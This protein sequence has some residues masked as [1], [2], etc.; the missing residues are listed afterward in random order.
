MS[1][2][3]ISKQSTQQIDV[4]AGTIIQPK[5]VPVLLTSSI[6]GIVL[7]PFETFVVKDD[8]TI[9]IS[10]MSFKTAVI[11][12]EVLANTV[13]VP[14][15]PVTAAT[16]GNK[17]TEPVIVGVT[18]DALSV[19]I[20]PT[21]ATKYTTSVSST[22]NIQL[23]AD[24]SFHA[25]NTTAG[26]ITLVV[27]NK[28]GSTVGDLYNI[29]AQNLAV[30]FPAIPNG[31]LGTTYQIAST[32]TPSGLTG[33]T[34]E[35]V[36]SDPTIASVT[37]SG[38]ITFVAVGTVTITVTVAYRG[39]QASYSAS[40][41]AIEPTE[42]IIDLSTVDLD[43]RVTI[44]ESSPTSRVYWDGVS[45]YMSVATTNEPSRQMNK[46]N[47]EYGRLGYTSIVTYHP[48]FDVINVGTD[49][50]NNLWVTNSLSD[51]TIGGSPN[52]INTNNNTITVPS[53]WT[54]IS[55]YNA[56]S[57]V[58]LRDNSKP[59]LTTNEAGTWK[60]LYQSLPTGGGGGSFYLY[61]GNADRSK[62]VYYKLT[63]L[64]SSTFMGS[65]FFRPVQGDPTKIVYSGLNIVLGTT[66]RNAATVSLGSSNQTVAVYSNTP[67]KWNRYEYTLD[68]GAV[69]NGSFNGTSR[70]LS[71]TNQNLYTKVRFY[72]L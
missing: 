24:K 20:V 29:T 34:Y 71:E 25:L 53:D 67:G 31:N 72:N 66:F 48:N 12:S 59:V 10:N 35:Y 2:I 45:E 57:G 42:E 61:I 11:A 51:I 43:P 17:P 56:T 28:D 13:V 22:A 62:Y 3:K 39:V 46:S 4:V 36:S 47:G 15:I 38:L 16:F 60:R 21:D 41:N 49:A 9:S 44:N 6:G 70:T 69:Q 54:Y 18:Y 68:S 63:G 65:M 50:T 7:N 14:A 5:T 23:N 30:T 58:F 8:S 64:P 19:N 37:N 33:V 27:T 40:V 52:V 32:V 1:D 26:S 55:W